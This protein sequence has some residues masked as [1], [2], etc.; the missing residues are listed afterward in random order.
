MKILVHEE[1]EVTS[2]EDFVANKETLMKEFKKAKRD[3]EKMKQLMKETLPYR[4]R[5]YK[6]K[7][8]SRLLQSVCNDYPMLKEVQYVSIQFYS[9]TLIYS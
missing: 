9:R 5:E 7:Y 2:E 1:S 8:E 4:R 3:E 6:T